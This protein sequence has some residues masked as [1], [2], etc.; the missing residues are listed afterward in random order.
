MS[1]LRIGGLELPVETHRAACSVQVSTDGQ[2]RRTVA[3]TASGIWPPALGAIDWSAPVTL[4]WIDL[5]QADTAW[6]SVSVQSPGPQIT[7]DLA[8]VTCS[9]TLTGIDADESGSAVTIDGT[10][11]L[12]SVA[13]E[14]RDGVMQVKTNGAATLLRANTRVRVTLTG[15]SRAAPAVSGVVAIVSPLYSGDILTFGPS[16]TYQQATGLVAWTLTGVQP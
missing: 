8:A 11:Y 16:A 13:I 7:S 15:E 5:A 12:A 4:D 14:P 6:V 1:R 9:W 2:G 3:I 10:P